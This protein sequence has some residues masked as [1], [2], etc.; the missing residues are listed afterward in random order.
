MPTIGKQRWEEASPL[1][2]F[3]KKNLPFQ[4]IGAGLIKI[5][6]EQ[7]LSRPRDH[8][9]SVI[10]PRVSGC[11]NVRDVRGTRVEEILSR[12]TLANLVVPPALIVFEREQAL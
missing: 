2:R 1:R 7:T 6:S 4:D 10:K 12:V 5:G 9:D 11:R 3:L 8:A